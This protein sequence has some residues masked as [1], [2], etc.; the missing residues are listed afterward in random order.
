MVFISWGGPQ[1]VQTQSLD[2]LPSILQKF[3]TTEKLILL[4]DILSKQPV[5]FNKLEHIVLGAIPLL[6]ELGQIKEELYQHMLVWVLDSLPIALQSDLVLN[7]ANDIV[8][9]INHVNISGLNISE[10]NN[11]VF[12]AGFA[13]RFDLFHT[14]IRAVD[15]I[16]K[17]IF[18]SYGLNP[19]YFN[20]TIPKAVGFLG[21]FLKDYGEKMLGTVIREINSVNTSVTA[22]NDTRPLEIKFWSQFSL[23]HLGM[24]EVDTILE[25]IFISNGLNPKYFDFTIP[26]AVGFLGEFLN[27][28]GEKV[29]GTAI[30][31]INSV[32]TSVTADNDARPLEIKFWSQFSLFHLGGS[33]LQAV[34]TPVEEHLPQ[35]QTGPMRDQCYSDVM[36]FL[37]NLFQGSK[38]AMESKAKAN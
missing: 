17:P 33:V 3:N 18:I 28:Y 9:E 6:S 20:L 31:E 30:R 19:K 32:N 27:D 7:V 8:D 23:L 2:E 37:N 5:L 1:T 26:K 38:W 15:T 36:A 13:Q 29:L 11:S 24:R 10:T 35:P 4:V 34:L 16:L 12:M 14:G 21:E 25:P 22:D